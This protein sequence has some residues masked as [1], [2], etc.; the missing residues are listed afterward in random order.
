MILAK[1]FSQGAYFIKIRHYY[2]SHYD[3][4][5]IEV[6]ASQQEIKTKYFELAKKYHPDITKNSSDSTKFLKIKEA[7]ETLSN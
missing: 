4:L 5:G 6:G 1:K 3:T 7:Y 2:S